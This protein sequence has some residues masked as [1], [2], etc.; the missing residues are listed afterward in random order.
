MYVCVCVG[1]SFFI[2]S[3]LWKLPKRQDE[4]VTALEHKVV[5]SL[6]EVTSELFYMGDGVKT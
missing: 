2:V 5:V 3:M 6:L 4:Y 1:I